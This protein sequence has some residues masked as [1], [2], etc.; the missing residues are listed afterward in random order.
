VA[1]LDFADALGD[2]HGEDRK[3]EESTCGDSGGH[4]VVRVEGDGC[5]EA[6]C[7][8]GG[9]VSIEAIAHPD[10]EVA[11]E[12]EGGRG[13]E[14][15]SGY[16]EGGGFAVEHPIAEEADAGVPSP[17]DEVG[18]GME[19]VSVGVDGEV[20]VGRDEGEDGED[21]L[22]AAAP[23][24]EEEQACTDRREAYAGRVEGVREDTAK[25]SE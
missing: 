15:G 4:D 3:A 14:D 8:A 17:G 24:A 18:A 20:V 6:G 13:G 5:D 21:G 22:P 23:R 16:A 19:G 11:E 10:D 12:E 1:V 2:V 7:K 9:G 25:N